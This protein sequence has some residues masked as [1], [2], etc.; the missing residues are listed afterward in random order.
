[1]ATAVEAQE[2]IATDPTKTDAERATAR[3]EIANIKSNTRATITAEENAV[4]AS[5]KIARDD[6]NVARQTLKDQTKAMKDLKKEAQ[7]NA[8]DQGYASVLEQS[9][10]AGSA[11]CPQAQRQGRDRSHADRRHPCRRRRRGAGHLGQGPPGTDEDRPHG[12]ILRRN[13]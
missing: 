8:S 1:M 7:K 6:I 4:K 11:L 13:T 10:H 2:L 5:I 12:L 3:T 9:G